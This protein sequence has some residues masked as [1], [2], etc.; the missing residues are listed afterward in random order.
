V[1]AARFVAAN[2]IDWGDFVDYRE[3]ASYF[4]SIGQVIDQIEPLVS[5]DP[6]DVADL[7]EY[8]IE[9][10]ESAVSN[11]VDDSDGYTGPILE[12]L[13]ELHVAACRKARF[14]PEQLGPRLLALELGAEYA[15]FE[16]LTRYKKAL[17]TRGL[18][19]YRKA[20]EARWAE[21]PAIKPGDDNRGYRSD[22]FR[23]TRVMEALARNDGG[24]EALV[25]VKSRNLSLP[26]HFYEIAE[27]YR[28]AGRHDQALAW[29]E[30][31]S[32]AFPKR[33]D[34]RLQGLLADEYHRRGRHAE[35][36]KLAWE[37]FLDR[38]YLESYKDLKR[39]ASL[40]GDWT[41]W[42]DRAISQLGRGDG[43]NQRLRRDRSEL[44][45]V[46]LWENAVEAAWQEAVAG[47]CDDGLW[48]QLATRR[49]A[50]DPGEV[51]PVY[52]RLAEHAIGRKDNR[53]YAEA[54]GLM[55]KMRHAM[56]RSGDEAAFPTYVMEVRVAHRPKRNLMKLLDQERW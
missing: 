15:E 10:L 4:R 8:G 45:N 17:G 5:T 25:A 22:R 3:A 48:L 19:A 29:A 51:I 28:E 52:R 13:V 54:V 43:A 41:G 42:R 20:A 2:A 6:A 27:L 7:A 50:D 1:N 40:A 32:A 56:E 46:L 49:E 23:I 39:H 38:P 11:G 36:M 44:V 16:V 47:G 31:G 53:S 37:H 33:L 34:W 24:L 35:A 9:A 18:A 26:Y 12:D 30:R 55:K 14:D 21:V